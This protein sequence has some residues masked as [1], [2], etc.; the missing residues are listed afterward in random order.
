M[1]AETD[2]IQ[3]E[4]TWQNAFDD[5]EFSQRLVTE[6]L[7]KYLN[8]C[9]WFA[10]KSSTIKHYTID[11]VLTIDTAAG[12]THIIVLEIITSRGNSESYLIPI[13]FLEYESKYASEKSGEDRICDLKMGGKEGCLVEATSFEFFRKAI[14]EHVLEGAVIPNHDGQLDFHRSRTLSYAKNSIKYE[15]SRLLGLEQSNTTIVYNDQYFLKF[16]RRLFIDPNP[17]YEL[18]RFLTEEAKFNNSPK[19]AG[20]INWRRGLRSEVTIALMQEKVENQ[21]DVWNEALKWVYTYF[22]NCELVKNP[23]KSRKLDPSLPLTVENIPKSMR[24]LATDD[25]LNLISL[26]ALRTAEMHIALASGKKNR[27]FWPQRYNEDYSVWVKNRLVHQFN[28][29]F[30]MVEKNIHRLEGMAVAYGEEFMKLKNFIIEKIVALDILRLNSHRIRIHGDYHLGQVLIS[31]N[32]FYIL[33][34]EGEPESTIRDRKVKQ[35]PLKD[36]AGILRSFHYAIYAVIFNQGDEFTFNQEELFELGEKYYAA[37]SAVFLNSYIEK[38]MDGGLDIGYMKEI[39]Y[40]L[41][42]HLLEK[43]IYEIGYELNSRPGWAII[44]LK[45]IMK[46]LNKEI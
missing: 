7:P 6:Y 40:L 13:Y 9:R 26:L 10:N 4:K 35:S 45:G 17:D 31:D 2:I 23:F 29:R 43:A 27:E 8:T 25:I 39:R 42:Y 20:S 5:Q 19:Y 22:S 44:P 30:N 33:D 46:I 24:E 11:D 12:P 21:G 41:Q 1:K 38:A 3:S 37:A 18:S 14:F 28:Y 16:Y 36:V 34:F 32:D 15:N